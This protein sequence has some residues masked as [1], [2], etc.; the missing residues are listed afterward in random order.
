MA[1]PSRQHP[2]QPWCS[3]WRVLPQ[4]PHTGSTMCSLDLNPQPFFLGVHTIEFLAL[5]R[6]EVLWPA[7]TMKCV[8]SCV[9]LLAEGGKSPGLFSTSS[10][11]QHQPRRPPSSWN[12]ISRSTPKQSP[13]AGW[14][15]LWARNRATGSQNRPAVFALASPSWKIHPVRTPYYNISRTGLALVVT[16]GGNA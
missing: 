6:L 2:A 10:L 16:V 9:A 14:D 3:L 7:L 8:Q 13:R 15:A 1:R 11:L 4:S 12:G 5:C